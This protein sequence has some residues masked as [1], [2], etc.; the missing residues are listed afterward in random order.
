MAISIQ[1]SFV[2]VFITY[3]FVLLII[4]HLLSLILCQK[5]FSECITF[6][7]KKKT[8]IDK[9]KHF[10]LH[11]KSFKT[12]IPMKIMP[13]KSINLF[14]NQKVVLISPEVKGKKLCLKKCDREGSWGRQQWI[15]KLFTL[16]ADFSKPTFQLSLSLKQNVLC[17]K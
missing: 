11:T 7:G 6:K 3:Y 17:K 12:N 14:K 1:D 5:L 16:L 15:Q 4:L 10:F 13:I 8:N 2:S 9:T